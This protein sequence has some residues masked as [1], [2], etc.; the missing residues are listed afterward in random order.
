M[1]DERCCRCD[2]T[3]KEGLCTDQTCLFAECEQNDPAGWANH[4]LGGPDPIPVLERLLQ[5]A[6]ATGGWEAPI[7]EEARRCWEAHKANRG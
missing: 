1:V 7:W 3:L 2:A 6:E 5:W 4:P